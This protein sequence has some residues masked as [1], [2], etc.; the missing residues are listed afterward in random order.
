MQDGLL[1]TAARKVVS[2]TMLLDDVVGWQVESVKRSG[3]G[4]HRYWLESGFASGAEVARPRS[5]RVSVV[6]ACPHRGKTGGIRVNCCGYRTH[7]AL[8]ASGQWSAFISVARK[9]AI[10]RGKPRKCRWAAVV[11]SRTR[12]R[13]STLRTGPTR[14]RRHR[15]AGRGEVI[16]VALRWYLRVLAGGRIPDGQIHGVYVRRFGTQ[17][18]Y[19]LL[20]QVRLR[21]DVPSV[22]RAILLHCHLPHP[23]TI[24]FSIGFRHFRISCKA[25]CR[26]DHGRC[27]HGRFRDVLCHTV[28]HVHCAAISTPSLLTL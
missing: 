7:G 9:P 19:R 11:A 17:N 10:V 22:S 4:V 3:V 15:L 1:N 26:V 2:P 12:G 21:T 14:F 13:D 6:I 20:Y 28:D 18:S 27:G 23:T 8:H 5:L 24:V 16:K 25:A